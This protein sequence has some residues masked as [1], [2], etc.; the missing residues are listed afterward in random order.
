MAASRNAK[1]KNIKRG[2]QSRDPQSRDAT[3][4]G[5]SDK[6]CLGDNISRG[7]RGSGVSYLRASPKHA[8]REQS[9]T[10]WTV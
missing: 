5:S 1:P 3:N 2:E 8:K 10:S 6:L 9:G 4:S 7:G